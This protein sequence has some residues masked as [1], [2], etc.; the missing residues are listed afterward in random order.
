MIDKSLYR[1]AFLC[2]TIPALLNI[3][4][5]D[6]FKF[7][8]KPEKWSKQEILGH[9]IDSASNNHQRFIRIQFEE[10]PKIIYD[11]N[12]WNKYNNWNALN[13]GHV[14]RFW[15][16]YNRQLI[17]LISIIPPENLIRTGITNEV[18]PVTLNWL[19][20]DYVVH[21]EHHMR[22]IVDY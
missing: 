13:K 7:K 5:E 8:A 4:P 9:L 2:E 20:D 17:E 16:V 6:E 21:L 1:L 10:N 22:Q 12:N 3:I 18:Q 11:Q 15:E 14:I 19:I